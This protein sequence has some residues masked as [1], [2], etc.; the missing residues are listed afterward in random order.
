MAARYHL[1]APIPDA[2]GARAVDIVKRLRSGELKPSQSDEVGDLICE[3]TDHTMRHYFARPA[4]AFKLGI[5][6]RGAIDLGIRSTVKTIRMAVKQVLPRLSPEQFAQ[7]ADYI[8]EA[9]AV[10]TARKPA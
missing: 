3:M 10:S 5:A 8:D 2:L 7:V 9:L 4:E 6:S 1:S